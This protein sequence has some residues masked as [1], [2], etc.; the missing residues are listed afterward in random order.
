VI[1]A[2]MTTGGG[3]TPPTIVLGLSA[4]NVRRLQEDKPILIDLAELGLPSQRVLIFTGTTEA[5]MAAELQGAGLRKFEGIRV[6][7]NP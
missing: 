2:L 5:E 7:E 3:T 1:K 6:Q 4:E